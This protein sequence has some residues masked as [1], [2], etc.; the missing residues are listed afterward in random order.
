M[1]FIVALLPLL[2]LFSG[3]SLVPKTPGTDSEDPCA[4]ES[5]GSTSEAP[6]ALQAPG[7]SSDELLAIEERY[8][9]VARER[10]QSWR[11]LIEAN[12]TQAL[13]E[14]LAKTNEFFNRLRFEDDS[15]HWGVDDYWATP[16]ETIATNGGDCEDFSVGKYFTLKELGIADQCLRLTY[17][18]ALTL[19]KP[20]WC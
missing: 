20:I 3:C 14:R 5:S 1:R 10:V 17:V 12:K 7:I 19:I 8:G 11:Q 15:V 18:K 16:I 13:P 2:L 9:K 4:P 6:C